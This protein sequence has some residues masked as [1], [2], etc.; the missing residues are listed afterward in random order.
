MAGDRAIAAGGLS[1]MP[2]SIGAGSMTEFVEVHRDNGTGTEAAGNH[3]PSLGKI[4]EG[5]A[6]IQQEGGREFTFA[7]QSIAIMSHL[8][9]VYLTPATRGIVPETDCVM[10]GGRRLNIVGVSIPDQLGPF[11]WLH[12]LEG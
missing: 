3:V 7:R 10:W 1:L 9:I 2:K 8:V 11:L 6:N 12:C 5:W 4:A